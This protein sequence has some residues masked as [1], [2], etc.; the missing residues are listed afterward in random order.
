MRPKFMLSILVLL[1]LV[2][3][4]WS[5]NE[6]VQS[7]KLLENNE[8][9]RALSI[10]RPYTVQHPE[11][12]EAACL[13]GDAY[14]AVGKNDSAEFIGKHLVDL[15]NKNLSAY[16]LLSKALYAQKK[17]VEGNK[18][19]D[20]GISKTK[21]TID[22]LVHKG[23]LQMEADSLMAAIVTFTQAQ[24]VDPSNLKV[25]RSLI[26][27]YLKVGVDAM[28]IIQIEKALSIDSTQIDLAYQLAKIHMA[29]R[30]YNDAA[31][32]YLIILRQNPENDQAAQELSQ[33]YI[34]AKQYGNASKI[35]EDYVKRHPEDNNAWL[36]F[37]EAQLKINQPE[38]ART[39]IEHVLKTEPN[40]VRG[41]RTIGMA[42]AIMKNW[43]KAAEY[44]GRL[45]KN[46]TLSAEDARLYGKSL[47]QVKN[48]TAA[49]RYLE[50]S[51]QKESD[52]KNVLN[53]LGAT[54]MRLKEWEKAADAFGRRILLDSTYATAYINLALCN[55]ALSKWQESRN[56]LKKALAI[57]PNYMRGHLYLA[58]CYGQMDSSN[59]SRI[60]YETVVKMIDAQI[61]EEKQQG[62]TATNF[63]AEFAESYKM[64]SLAYLVKKDYP[65]AAKALEKAVEYKQG[66]AE[67]HLWYAQTLH[68][69]D[70]RK[71]AMT[72]YEKVLKIDPNNKAAKD[73]ILIL[74]QYGG[75]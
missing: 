1:A 7:K 75:F 5:Q 61:E 24:N 54:Y 63:K 13:L 6:L 20:K 73:G 33:L 41:L 56:S 43:P 47:I 67:L 8:P 38:D 55:M 68:A 70:N 16:I 4:V 49:A 9:Q 34:A 17:Y 74:K 52:Q 35:L 14:L 46:D 31:K 11:N 2:V 26:N 28:A 19:L 42:E 59:A 32:A 40:T 36:Q 3:T 66:D 72:Q 44:Y 23:T 48:D 50:F 25:Y 51:I 53:D 64:I 12:A 27:S 30:R 37:G 65:N 60:E 15:S 39:A 18:V 58:R 62:K 45:A 21:S 10:L 71:E 57:Q 69:L 29:K 22:L